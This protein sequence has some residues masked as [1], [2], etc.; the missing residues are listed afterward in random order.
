MTLA[1]FLERKDATA[2]L[3]GRVTPETARLYHIHAASLPG[4]MLAHTP[5]SIEAAS[6]APNRRNGK[7]PSASLVHA[8]LASWRACYRLAIRLGVATTNPVE[9]VDAMRPPKRLPRAVHGDKAIWQA[10]ETAEERAVVILLLGLGLRAS[11]ALSVGP[12][13]IKGGVL[14]VVGKG[15]KERRIPVPEKWVLALNEAAGNTGLFL[16]LSYRQLTRRVMA[17][18][19]AAQLGRLTPHQLRHGFATA[20]L[21]NGADLEHVRRLLG[22]SDTRTTLRYTAGASMDLSGAVAAANKGA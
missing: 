12:K 5:A 18:S 9:P 8:R 2:L 20:A 7:A 3:L 17:L 1:D 15:N 4:D 11:E 19:E 10:V 14:S 21:E 22:H 6:R 13:D 16:R